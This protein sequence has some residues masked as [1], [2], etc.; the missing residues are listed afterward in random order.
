MYNIHYNGILVNQY[1][2]ELDYIGPHRDDKCILGGNV[3]KE[4]TH[5]MPI[6]KKITGS[7]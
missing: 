2:N 4:F 7:R 1:M 6:G 3:Q 5:K